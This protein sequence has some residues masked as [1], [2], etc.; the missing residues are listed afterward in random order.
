MSTSDISK[1]GAS[2]SK[3]DDDVCEEIGKLQNMSTADDKDNAS[4]C[5][6]CGKEGAKN[7]CN[8]CK[9]VKY[10]NAACKKKHRHKHKKD[11]EEHVRHAAELHDEKLFK[12]PPSNEDCPICFIRLPT[13]RPTGSKYKLCCGKVICCG[14]YFAPIY[15]NQGNMVD[16]DKQNQCPFCRVLAPKSGEVNERLNKRLKLGDA[17]A[18]HNVGCYY[19]GATYGY[20]QDD[21][22]ALQLWHRAGELGYSE[23]YVCIGYAYSN[24]KGVEIDEKKADYYYEIAAMRGNVK[25]RCN[26]G[27]NEARAGNF[28]R[29]LKHYM[30]A[31]RGGYTGSLDTIREMY[32]NGH[33]AKADYTKALQLYQKY[34]GEIKSTQRDEAAAADEKYRYY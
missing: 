18:I 16:E 29:A 14:C 21:T 6:N 3:C 33:A 24:G 15:D 34:L 27:N 10:C 1:D 23:A 2:K 4:I 9:E 32:T 26:L 17:I 8:K 30:I 28:E 25:A 22:K 31:V 7:I 19:R 13:L 12:E 5:A 20:P 11:C